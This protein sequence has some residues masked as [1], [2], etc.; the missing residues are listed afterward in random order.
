MATGKV[1]FQGQTGT[2]VLSAIIRDQPVPASRHNAE[3]PQEMERIISKCLEKDPDDRYQDARDLVV[4]LRKLRRTTD[5]GVQVVRETA[6]VGRG[7]RRAVAIGAALALCVTLGGLVWFSTHRPERSRELALR[8]LTA[9]PVEEALRDAAISPDGKYLAYADGKGI[10]LLLIETG[11]SH[12]I[13]LSGRFRFFEVSWFPDSARL[14]A[15]ARGEAEG[16]QGLWAFPLLGGGPRRLRDDAW[17]GR[18]SPDGS[19]IA[20]LGG[21]WPSREIWLMGPNGEEPTKIVQGDEGEA[22]FWVVWSPDGGRIAYGGR[23]PL[24]GGPAAD[25]G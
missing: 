5:S 21:A 11:E 2:D 10:H 15:V 17:G 8:Q 22:F 9:N 12:P 1:P 16:K 23:E 25:C 7:H 4:D 19:R 6:A 24:G 3:V 18:V 20:F 13:Q 14:I